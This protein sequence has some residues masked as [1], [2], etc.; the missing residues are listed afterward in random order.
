VVSF[1]NYIYFNLPMGTFALPV[2]Q[3]RVLGRIFRF[4]R[5]GINGKMERITFDKLHNMYFS[6]N[7]I[8]VIIFKKWD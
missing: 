5:V 6:P 7:I 3:K 2:L 8:R 1:R 4:K